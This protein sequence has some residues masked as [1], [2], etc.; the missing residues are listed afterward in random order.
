M[1]GEQTEASVTGMEGARGR[2]HEVRSGQV[3][4][5][6]PGKDLGFCVT[7]KGKPLEDFSWRAVVPSDLHVERFPLAPGWRRESWAGVAS[8]SSVMGPS[9][10]SHKVRGAWP[11]QDWKWEVRTMQLRV[12]SSSSSGIWGVTK[13]ERSKRMG[14]YVS[15]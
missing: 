13:K 8:V 9:I 12:G 3:G 14:S 10:A 1:L 4:L 7:W 2:W 11:A 15:G 5:C 6:W